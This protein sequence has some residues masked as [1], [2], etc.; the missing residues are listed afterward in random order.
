M[1][2]HSV[3][4]FRGREASADLLTELLRIVAQQ[5]VYQPVEAELRELLTQHSERRT[6]DGKAGVVRTAICPS[7]SCRAVWAGDGT[8][9]KSPSLV[10]CLVLDAHISASPE[11]SATNAPQPRCGS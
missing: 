6:A 10:S 2:K 4:E 11:G 5:L 1:W 9:P 7:A 8:E 3:V